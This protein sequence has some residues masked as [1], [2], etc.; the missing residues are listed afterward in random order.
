MVKYKVNA[1]RAMSLNK[2]P[3][4]NNKLP[5]LKSAISESSLKWVDIV[6]I[7]PSVRIPVNVSVDKKSS[8]RPSSITKLSSTRS[9]IEVIKAPIKPTH[10]ES[11]NYPISINPLKYKGDTKRTYKRI[12]KIDRHIKESEPNS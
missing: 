5:E 12:R 3:S 2:P 11:E 4:R 7:N 1:Y 9:Q 10:N 6:V 8:T